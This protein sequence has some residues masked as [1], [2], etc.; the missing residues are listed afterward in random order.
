M[1][2]KA[3]FVPILILVAF[4]LVACGSM[5]RQTPKQWDD[6]AIKADVK[7]KIAEVYP[8]K[9]FDIGVTVDHQVVSLTGTVE[10]AEQAKKIGEAAQAVNGVTRVIN[11]IQVK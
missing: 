2:R 9:T 11:N 1:H 6:T 7:G 4:G 10:T 5:N 3:L 8:S